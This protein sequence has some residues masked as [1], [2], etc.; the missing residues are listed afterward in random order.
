MKKFT[1]IFAALFAADMVSAQIYLEKT[2]NGRLSNWLDIEDFYYDCGKLPIIYGDTL[3]ELYND[4][5]TLYKSVRF[6]SNP[7]APNKNSVKRSPSALMGGPS[8]GMFLFARNVYTTD[9]K[10]AF[11]R[12]SND[13]AAVYDEDGQLVSDLQDMSFSNVGLFSVNGK[14][15]LVLQESVWTWNEETQT[16]KSEYTTFIYALPG[17]GDSSVDVMSPVSPRRSST[18]KYLHNDQVLIENADHTYTMQGQEVK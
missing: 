10:V 16:G 11:V 1:I 15:K 12:W 5:M 6:A 8:Q 2:I 13:H 14:W 9:G 17:N 18:R 7:K 3:V 4:D